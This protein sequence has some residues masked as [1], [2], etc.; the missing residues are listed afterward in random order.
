VISSLICHL[1]GFGI[2][3]LMS[4]FAWT[5]LTVI[6]ELR[7]AWIMARTWQQF[8][9]ML[10]VTQ[11]WA[12]LLV[13]GWIVPMSSTTTLG[14]SFERFGGSIVVILVFAIVFAVVYLVGFS[15]AVGR[16]NTLEFT[17]STAQG[18]LEAARRAR[19]EQNYGRAI[20]EFEQYVALVGSTEQIEA[21]LRELRERVR[22]DEARAQ[23][24]SQAGEFES[25]TA[26][27]PGELLDR[28]AAAMNASDFSTAH[29]MA[30]LARALDPTND[31]A[32]RIAAEALARLESIGPTGDQAEDADLFN[33]KQSA[34]A[35]LT[36]LDFVSAYYEFASIAADYPLDVDAQR[37]LEAARDS[38]AGQTVFY[39]DVT[40]ALAL[41]GST[42]LAFVSRSTPELIEFVSIG[43][44]V[45]T[46][47]GVYAGMIEVFR[48]SPDGRVLMHFVSEYGQLLDG[49]LI[50][51]VIS[52]G[53][54][55]NERRPQYFV[56]QTDA[57]VEGIFPIE[58]DANELFLLA[59][60]SRDPASA[61][62]TALSQTVSALDNY[63][64]LSE[65]VEL[66]F[67]QRIA[68]PFAFVIFSLFVMGFAWRY[69][70]RYLSMPPIPTLLLV[71]LA[72]LVILPVYLA[73]L[74]GQRL[75][76]GAL[77]L[78]SGFMATLIALVIVE[79]LLL[80]FTLMYVALGSRE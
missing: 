77:L 75:I 14:T 57:L 65:P 26:A 74:Y 44:L 33:R 9:T 43:K 17:S 4:V 71:P 54:E 69:R 1:V 25:A 15:A 29:Y 35:A 11:A 27:S 39:E 13:F 28:A 3:L 80:L 48:I 5:S 56:G 79:G 63:G 76:L 58:P 70:S 8:L 68:T 55:R 21:D 73:F 42:D 31:E 45:R 37:Y 23:V 2:V 18:R 78:S 12:V 38:V 10:P 32:A 41:P 64:L 40:N 67:L 30:T 72:P 47:D 34:K 24:Q 50:M 7:W 62:T 20:A 6:P 16:V 52:R 49:R 36:R 59:S 22:A 51:N 53:T 60:V 61:S 19:S 66:E 46:A